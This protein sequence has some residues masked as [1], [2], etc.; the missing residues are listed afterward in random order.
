VDGIFS[1]MGEY[2]LETYRPGWEVSEEENPQRFT[3]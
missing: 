1:A 2:N 3:A